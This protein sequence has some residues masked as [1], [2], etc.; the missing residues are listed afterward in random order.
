MWFMNRI[1]WVLW[2]PLLGWAAMSTTRAG[3]FEVE[4]VSGRDAVAVAQCAERQDLCLGAI[5]RL[6]DRKGR[7]PDFL[8]PREH[9]TL[10]Q[11]LA[12]YLVCRAEF[13][14]IARRQSSTDAELANVSLRCKAERDVQ[15][16]SLALDDQVLH[17]ALNQSFHRSGIERGRCDRIIDDVIASKIV[18]TGESQERLN[19]IIQ[20]R[21][22]LLPSLEIDMRQLRPVQLL[23]ASGD[24]I[25]GQLQQGQNCAL[26]GL[27]R[28]KTPMTRPLAISEEQR[29]QI[30]EMLRPGDILLT[31]TSGLTSNLIIPGRFK[32]A[33]IF[34]GTEEERRYCG[35]GSERL[36]AFATPHNQPLRGVLAQST[37]RTG[38]SAD[39]VESLSEGVLLNNFEHMLSTRVNQLAVLRP[40]L[41]DHERAAQLVDVLSYVG[42]RFDFSFDLTE[43]SAQV[44]T[45][46][47]YRSLQGRGG[48][49]IPLSHYAGRLTLT[50]DDLARYAIRERGQFLQCILLA[51]QTPGTAGAPRIS[52]AAEAQKRIAQLV[53]VGL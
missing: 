2:L 19:S 8:T 23:L 49:D 46:V 32:H 22:W 28:I 15:L 3:G 25:S 11:S 48:I 7:V 38:K 13:E 34:V 20:R 26:T 47:V 53:G 44:C 6:R 27:G 36:L 1:I 35:F 43:A 40:S 29:K 39:V 51:E 37:T 45:E 5:R 14:Q 21:G 41:S 16:A 12:E 31:Y 24:A 17:R 18:L 42:D 10:E 52:M 50:A 30:R 9:D 33:A 4:S